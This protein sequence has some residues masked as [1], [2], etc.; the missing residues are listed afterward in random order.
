[1]V[2]FGPLLRLNLSSGNNDPNDRSTAT[3]KYHFPPALELEYGEPEEL[4]YE[5]ATGSEV[6]TRKWTNATVTLD[7][8]NWVGTIVS[9]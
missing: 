4:C 1:M 3:I 7:C 6:F 2:A 9:G 8:K 5:T